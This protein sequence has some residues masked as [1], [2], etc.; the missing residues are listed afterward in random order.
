MS[1]EQRFEHFYMNTF[2][3]GQASTIRTDAKAL[4]KVIDRVCPEGREKS[5]AL[6]KL[7]EVAMWAIKSIDHGGE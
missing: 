2:Q 7:E 4:A 3:S 6:T 5:L 1:V